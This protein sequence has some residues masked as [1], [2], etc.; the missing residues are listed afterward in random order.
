MMYTFIIPASQMLPSDPAMFYRITIFLHLEN[1]INDI[2]KKKYFRWWNLANG[3]FLV[4]DVKSH[5]EQNEIGYLSGL[6]H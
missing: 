5:I 6:V 3:D 1:S 2:F 4:W